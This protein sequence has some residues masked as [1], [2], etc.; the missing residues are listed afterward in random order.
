VSHL[1]IV[2]FQYGGAA[3]RPF[4]YAETG[5]ASNDMPTSF[6][7]CKEKELLAVFWRRLP[8]ENAAAEGAKDGQK[9]SVRNILTY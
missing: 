4:L 9:E 7:T 2:A 8:V 5:T 6:N 3:S 1:A